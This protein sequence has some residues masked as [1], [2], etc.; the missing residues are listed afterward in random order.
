MD[1]IGSIVDKISITNIKIYV[2]EDKKRHPNATNDEIAE[3]TKKTN[4]LNTL[5]CTLIDE[6]DVA[7]NEIAKGHQQKLF[8]SNKQYGGK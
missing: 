4:V 6:L 7:M 3:A 2:L 1:S 8:G 5:R